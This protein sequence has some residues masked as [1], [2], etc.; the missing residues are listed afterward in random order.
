MQG[1]VS[2]LHDAKSVGEGLQVKDLLRA[3]QELPRR[4]TSKTCL[5]GSKTCLRTAL[6]AAAQ[7]S[8]GSLSESR[9]SPLDPGHGEQQT[10]RL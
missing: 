2:V 6:Y 3:P 4:L 1:F 9:T 8:D 10:I 7:T 5:T